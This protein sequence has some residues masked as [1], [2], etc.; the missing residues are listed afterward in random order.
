[1]HVNIV[2]ETVL[3][4]YLMSQLD[5]VV[6]LMDIYGYVFSCLQLVLQRE[7]LLVLG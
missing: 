4:C 7:E 1:M 2:V 5:E 3:C 6:A